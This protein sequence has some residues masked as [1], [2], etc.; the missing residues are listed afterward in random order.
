M[1]DNAMITTTLTLQMAAGYSSY[2]PRLS[3]TQTDN[4][5]I[6]VQLKLMNKTV[7]YIVP[8][9]YDVNIRAEKPDGTHIYKPVTV[10]NGVYSFVLGGQLTTAEGL[11]KCAIE[12]V[13]G[14]FV[15]HSAKF[16]V[17]VAAQIAPD[18]EIVSDDDMETLNNYISRAET[19]A[20]KAETAAIKQP[21]VGSNG[22]WQIWNPESGQYE[23]SGY[24]A[25]G[26]G[27]G[28]GSY[29]IG[30]GLKLDASTNTL[31]VDVATSVEEDNTKPITSAAVHTTVGNI[32]TLLETI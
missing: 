29:V 25:S 21:I 14:E 15:L 6:N 19:A 17:D 32:Q 11:S 20:E 28:G 12:I 8:D 4:E 5:S 27:S 3:C 2:T 9:G 18:G 30:S 22:N 13:K 16:E 24:P 10:E 31:S 1:A 26:G 7:P 23:D